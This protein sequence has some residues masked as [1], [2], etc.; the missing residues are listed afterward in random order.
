M[1]EYPSSTRDLRVGVEMSRGDNMVRYEG[2]SFVQAWSC[3]VLQDDAGH[4]VGW[5]REQNGVYVSN[6]SMYQPYG[7]SRSSVR[8]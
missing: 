5:V 7:R 6:L 4:L 1:I 8:Q 2:E 3:A